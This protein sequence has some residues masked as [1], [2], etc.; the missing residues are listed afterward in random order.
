M[1]IK[2]IIYI[3]S[4]T[5]PHPEP[6]SVTPDSSSISQPKPEKPTKVIET[7]KEVLLSPQKQPLK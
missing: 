7:K 6:E 3:F 4:Q 2:N 1:N 5:S